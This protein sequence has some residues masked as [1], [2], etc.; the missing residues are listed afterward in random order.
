ML[1]RLRFQLPLLNG[2]GRCVTRIT[3]TGLALFAIL[4]LRVFNN[5]FAECIF[6]T[7]KP[8]PRAGIEILACAL[9][10]IVG[11]CF[12]FC[13]AAWVFVPR[14]CVL[15][16]AAVWK[17]FN[18]LERKLDK[19]KM[20][21]INIDETSLALAP[22]QP[23]GNVF[24][25]S[26]VGPKLHL[27]ARR[28][29]FTHIA[30]VCDRSSLQPF[31]PQW[32]VMNEKCCSL[33]MFARLQAAA[34]PNIQFVR[35]K[36][37][38]NNAGLCAEYVK[39][40]R[41]ALEPHLDDL[42]VCLLWDACKVHNSRIVL[43]ACRGA[44]FWIVSIPPPTTSKLQ[45]LDT[46]VFAPF[47]RELAEELQS[48]RLQKAFDDPELLDYFD[49]VAKAMR[50]VFQGSCW[51]RAFDD[52]GFGDSQSCVS[53]RVAPLQPARTGQEV[54]SPLALADIRLCFA[55]RSAVHLDLLLP[56][57]L[58]SVRAA[59]REATCLHHWM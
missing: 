42:Q 59:H 21:R 25:R 22:R 8:R 40:L 23:R 36:S 47:K 44:R 56:F 3:R 35:Q 28:T 27:R 19:R 12:S 14:F 55:R 38:W 1:C 5:L 33:A 18:N 4:F 52:N 26:R 17:W 13:V 7:R 37:A 48:L 11:A 41:A 2:K 39:A 31:L 9:K 15:E 58:V 53:K 34:P 54:C 45:I 16:A 10:C 20:L 24:G 43:S 50:R 32:I 46:H 51:S 6:S 57:P 49:C 30:C 29:C